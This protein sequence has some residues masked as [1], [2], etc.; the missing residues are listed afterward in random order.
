M[1]F[2][3]KFKSFSI[4][5]VLSAFLAPYLANALTADPDPCLVNSAGTVA[6][7]TAAKALDATAMV[8]SVPT[9]DDTLN[10]KLSNI[11]S[12]ECDAKKAAE[13]I[14][15]KEVGP[16]IMGV[17]LG[18]AFSWDSIAIIAARL[19][20]ERIVDS[21]LEWI[22]SGFEGSP[23][24][25]T[26]PEEYFTGI[27]DSVAGQFIEGSQLSGLCSPFQADI[28][29]ALSKYYNRNYRNSYTSQCTF[30]GAVENIRNFGNDFKDRGWDSW[31]EITQTDSN[32]PYG[33]YVEAQASLDLSIASALNIEKTKLD[34]GQGF[35]S[36]A[37]C[38]AYNPQNMSDMTGDILVDRVFVDKTK[39]AGACIKFG[40]DKTPGTVIKSQVDKV[41][42]TGLE[43]LIT[44]DEFNEIIS[45]L[46]GQLLNRTILGAQGLL[47]SNQ[48]K[49]TGGTNTT[50]TPT[51]TP[52][53]TTPPP[54]PPEVERNPLSCIGTPTRADIN[55]TMVFWTLDNADTDVG[56]LTWDLDDD[57]SI[58]IEGGN[59]I[60]VTYSEAGIKR[61]V[62]SSL[63]SGT[64]N[65]CSN[66]VMVGT[67]D[68]Q[69]LQ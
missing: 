23:A 26:D 40:P 25:V 51:T 4:L 58:V 24:F 67:L 46:M 2:I 14:A 9:H 30:S 13:A 37:D 7:E 54:P 19:V 45:A 43:Q 41:L 29:I 34:W 5:L 27:A 56:G 60:G 15:Q 8:L 47:G 49:V 18:S 6:V 63:E 11:R 35:K 10:L 1:K 16:T 53:P 38:I 69:E 55:S 65:E 31:F 62:V 68:P 52:P 66:S 61:A 20:V 64:S 28:K 33:A 12:I 17:P 3:N 59:A 39:P 36:K 48:E 57:A 22:N 50:Y 21:T 44:A 42:P 32:N